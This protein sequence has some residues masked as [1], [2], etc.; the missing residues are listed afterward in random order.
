[1]IIIVVIIVGEK[2][3]EIV[4]NVNNKYCKRCNRRLKNTE[5]QKIG[6]GKTCYSKIQINQ[7][8]YLFD[9]EAKDEIIDKDQI[10]R[11]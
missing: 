3:V 7:H 10:Q 8:N 1:M 5:S 4:E 11:N 2:M 6:Y 9:L